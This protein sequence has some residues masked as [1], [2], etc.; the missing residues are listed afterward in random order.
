MIDYSLL[1]VT[2]ASMLLTNVDHQRLIMQ[3]YLVTDAFAGCPQHER[4][5]GVDLERCLGELV[6]AL[7]LWRNVLIAKSQHA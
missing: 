1:T 2:G 7:E 3:D 6:G 5:M 4:V